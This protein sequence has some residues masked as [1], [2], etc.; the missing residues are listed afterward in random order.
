V[1]REGQEKMLE[2]YRHARLS[3]LRLPDEPMVSLGV[4]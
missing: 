3:E 4:R 1:W 2:V